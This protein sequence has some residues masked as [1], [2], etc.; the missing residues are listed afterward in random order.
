MH[1]MSLLRPGIR[2]IGTPECDAEFE[3]AVVTV[4]V[5]KAP[6]HRRLDRHV[7]YYDPYDGNGSPHN[8]RTEHFDDT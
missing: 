4:T 7:D 6:G 5:P 8:S 3:V 2:R 1:R